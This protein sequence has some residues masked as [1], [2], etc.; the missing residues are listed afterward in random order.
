MLTCFVRTDFPDKPNKKIK[1]LIFN[2]LP[3]ISIIYSYYL[4]FF[5]LGKSR[6]RKNKHLLAPFTKYIMNV[7]IFYLLNTPFFILLLISSFEYEITSEG[8]L[9]W[10]SYVK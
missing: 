6:F 9:S 7:G 3:F 2:C 5:V 4:F 1:V 10:F 8:F